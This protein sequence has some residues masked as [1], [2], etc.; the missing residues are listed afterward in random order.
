[1]E[2]NLCA[3][4]AYSQGEGLQ[5]NIDTKEMANARLEKYCSLMTEAEL[6]MLAAFA[7]GLIKGRA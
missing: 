7:Y 2:K 6:K 4:G 5:P 3:K 1:M